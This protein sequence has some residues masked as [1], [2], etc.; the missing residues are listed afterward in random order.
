VI[1]MQAHCMRIVARSRS[2]MSMES[3][4]DLY[5][6]STHSSVA[7]SRLGHSGYSLHSIFGEDSWSVAG[8]GIW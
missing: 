5:C 3:R 6:F 7:S 2:D 8:G 1:I 4:Y